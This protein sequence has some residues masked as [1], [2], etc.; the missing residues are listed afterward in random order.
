MQT[1]GL[2]AR[3]SQA[4]AFL[5]ADRITNSMKRAMDETRRR[6]EKQHACNLEH[7][8]TQSTIIRD[9]SNILG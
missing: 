7:G 1:I 3:N 8:I 6:R 9:A 5:Y 4:R 2:A